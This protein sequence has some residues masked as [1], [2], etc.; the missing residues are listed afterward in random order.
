M[1]GKYLNV[2]YVY[3]CDR[4]FYAQDFR[5]EMRVPQWGTIYPRVTTYECKC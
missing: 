4:F 3:V 5:E 1:K 2:I